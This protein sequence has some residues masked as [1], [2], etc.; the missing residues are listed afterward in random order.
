ME[1]A[2]QTSRPILV[3][4]GPLTAGKLQQDYP[5][6]VVIVDP[7][8]SATLETHLARVINQVAAQQRDRVL[9]KGFALLAVGLILVA[10][11]DS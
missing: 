2:K 11:L 1:Y 10:S 6:G 7:N 4:A 9:L 3:F 8:D 5:N